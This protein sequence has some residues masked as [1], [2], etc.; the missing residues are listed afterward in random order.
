MRNLY[1]RLKQLLAPGFYPD[2]F[3]NV[4]RLAEEASWQA[5]HP[6]GLYVLSRMLFSLGD[7]WTEQGMETARAEEM[8][9]TMEPAITGFVTAGAH[10]LTPDEEVPYLN[11]LIRA[12]L[13]WRS[14]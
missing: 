8:A 14:R 3:L 4:A 5:E 6:L 1:E 9:R 12:F 7:G 2:N 10:G 11:D 13:R